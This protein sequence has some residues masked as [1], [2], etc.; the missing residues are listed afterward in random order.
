MACHARFNKLACLRVMTDAAQ[1]V[2]IEL[3]ERQA[4]Q[5]PKADPQCIVKY[6]RL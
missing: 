2:R 6:S 5:L 1:G 4:D 3:A